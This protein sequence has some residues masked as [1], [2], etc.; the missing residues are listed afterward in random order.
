MNCTH[1]VY[2]ARAKPSS[3]SHSERIEEYH[4]LSEIKALRVR[5]FAA[6]SMTAITRHPPETRRYLAVNRIFSTLDRN[7]SARS[8][9]LSNCQNAF[10]SSSSGR[11]SSFAGFGAR[12][13][14]K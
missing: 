11:R 8:K 14:L 12:R 13:A 6:L 2:I 1:G 9:F 7:S 4:T 10:D 5:C 3:A